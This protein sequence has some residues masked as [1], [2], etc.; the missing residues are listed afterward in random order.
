MDIEGIGFHAGAL[1]S[2]PAA[3]AVLRGSA[4]PAGDGASAPAGRVLAPAE[5]RRAPDSVRV[6][7]DVAL[8]AC[9]MA[10]REPATLASVFASGQGDLAITDYLCRTLA[11]NPLDLSPT[12]FHNSV[13]NAA[14]GY[15]TIATGCHQPS[16][17]IS[18]GDASFAAGLLEAATEALCEDAAV[19]LVAF[20]TPAEGP[21][22]DVC[23]GR[24][25][26]GAALVLAPP[27]S[28]RRVAGLRL[29][30]DHDARASGPP[31]T[32]VIDSPVAAGSLA[33]FD[34]L[35]AGTRRQIVLDGAGAP[36]LAIEVT[37]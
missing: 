23:P 12:R 18:A 2:W 9:S 25:L 19:I 29:V 4:A 22:S 14:A 35:A 7:C 11:G 13:H 8:E 34:A 24:T 21:M 37:P 20:D 10:G 15:W 6:A 28:A 16:T 30:I 1:A 17:A 3:A 32:L 5:R 27:G 26:F 33:L 31:A 36:A